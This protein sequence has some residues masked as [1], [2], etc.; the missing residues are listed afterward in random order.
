MHFATLCINYYTR[1]IGNESEKVNWISAAYFYR[2]LRF[3]HIG[4]DRIVAHWHETLSHRWWNRN[5]KLIK[6]IYTDVRRKQIWFIFLDAFSI[7]R[8]KHL[9]R[10]YYFVILVGNK[11]DRR[12]TLDSRG[13]QRN[14]SKATT[15]GCACII[16]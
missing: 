13:M 16:I 6:V 12:P 11:R 10:R 9:R 2:Q 3:V 5:L 15:K 1:R 4:Y 14:N 8:W 7:Q